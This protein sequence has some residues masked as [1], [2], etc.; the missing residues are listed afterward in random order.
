MQEFIKTVG[1]VKHE[2]M[3]NYLNLSYVKRTIAMN[4]MYFRLALVVTSLFVLGACSSTNSRY[5]TYDSYNNPSS[6]TDL[7]INFTKASY[8]SVPKQYRRDY[9]ACVSDGLHHLPA[10]ASCRFGDNIADGS[11]IVAVVYPNGCQTLASR[12]TYK[13]K[14]KHWKETHCYRAGEWRLID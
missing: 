5:S 8:Y 6:M 11:V 3:V 12:L 7:A 4:G 1:G 2:S 14:Q 13:G 9:Q 10:G